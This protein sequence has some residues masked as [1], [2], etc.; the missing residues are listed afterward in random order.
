VLAVSA[1]TNLHLEDLDAAIRAHHHHLLATAMLT[2][3][4]AE[5]TLAW[6]TSELQQEVGRRGVLT[7]GGPEGV[8]HFW[9]QQPV[10]WSAPHR[11]DALLRSL[12]WHH[13]RTE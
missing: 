9:E 12:Q 11:L 10:Q 5:Q 8:K 6:A 13:T 1:A 2:T 7:L 3:K 4:R